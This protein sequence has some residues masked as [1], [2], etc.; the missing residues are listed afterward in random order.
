MGDS[1]YTLPCL[2]FNDHVVQGRRLSGHLSKI[3]DS[4]V[5]LWT[6]AES[7]HKDVLNR[8]DR[9]QDSTRS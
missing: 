7:V 8:V 3:R 9:W 4:R 2:V 5:W 1:G 6:R